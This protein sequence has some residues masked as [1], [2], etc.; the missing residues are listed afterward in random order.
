[1]TALLEEY[2]GQIGPSAPA[3]LNLRQ[4]Y[5]RYYST[6]LYAR[7]Y[8]APNRHILDLI[9]S[10]LGPAGGHV[11]D[12]GCGSGRYA[13]PLA[14]QTGVSVFGYDISAAAI[15]ELDGKSQALAAEGEARKPQLETLCG[16][17]DDLDR[18]LAG[19]PGF[20][21]V[22]LLF[23]VLG[24]V[25][26]RHRRLALLRSLGAKLRPGGRLIATVPNRARRFRAEQATARPLVRGGM[27]EPGDIRYRRPGAGDPIE[28]FYHLYS[29]D[30]FRGELAEAGFVVSRL[31]PESV[32]TERAILASPMCNAAD[33]VLRRAAPLSLAYGFVAV[34]EIAAAP[35]A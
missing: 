10:E 6:G 15:R 16:S 34:A 20:D 19:E 4:S 1:M 26:H 27:L 2:R 7:R 21:L 9:L 23:G 31:C 17:L 8:P 30:E 28:L 29:L 13:L 32:L 5:D 33:R 11:L 24:H 3:S 12:F 18:R 35:T 14:M 22:M 25:Q